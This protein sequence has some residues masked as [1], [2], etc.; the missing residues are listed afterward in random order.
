MGHQQV[1]HSDSG[2]RDD[3]AADSNAE[4]GLFQKLKD[5]FTDLF[6]IPDEVA[7]WLAPALF[8]G[9]K[10]VRREQVD[11]LFATGRPWTTLV[12]GAALKII[13]RK[14]LVVDFRDPWMTNPFRREHSGFKNRIETMLERWVL[15]TADIVVAN[16]DYL[17]EEF[18]ER[19]GKDLERK[20]ITVLNGFDP[21]EFAEVEPEIRADSRR[22]AFLMVHPGFL[23][24]KRDPRI[25]VDALA[26]LRDQAVIKPGEFICELIGPVE[27]PY[28]LDALIRS[29]KLE[30]FLKLR[31]PVSYR[32]SLSALASCDVALLLQPGT[33]TQIP[34][35]LFEFVGFGKTM[36]AVAPLDSSVAKIINANKLG[37]VAS[38]EDTGAV[39]DAIK[40]V[41]SQWRATGHSAR[42]P[43]DIQ[44]E[45]DVRR[46]VRKLGDA[47]SDL[48]NSR[49]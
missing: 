37:V 47:M 11:V 45:F 6:E 27:L 35:K 32:E 41:F 10:I 18:V 2:Q 23:Y 22:S 8:A 49:S 44:A 12:I 3:G 13:T 36:I 1:E 14:P 42:I 46:S 38:A 7:G 19:F 39:A 26:T 43:E 15:K 33:S 5:A 17:R 40:S 48:V 16:T 34:S 28:D 21:E 29:L 4:R 31:G 25:L 20:C 9:V 30:E 24:G